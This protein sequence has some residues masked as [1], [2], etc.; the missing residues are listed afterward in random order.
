M[1]ANIAPI[2]TITPL[3]S[4]GKITAADTGN[5]G[6]GA[7][8]VLV[9]TAGANGDFLYKLRFQPLSTSGSISTSL[10]A[11]RIYINNGTTV[12]TAAN[13]VL[14]YEVTLPVVAVSAAATGQEAGIDYGMNIQ[15]QAG[16]KV[17]VGATVMTANSQWNVV[18]FCGDY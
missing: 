2:Y 10:A 6:T 7:N 11:A 12:G 4:W 15:I 5:D 18:A 8:V 17:Y 1:T 14:T 13:N 9:M 16:Y 3:N